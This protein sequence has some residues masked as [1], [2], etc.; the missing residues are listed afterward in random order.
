MAFV[1]LDSGTKPLQHSF[2]MRP[3]HM[4]SL[5]D[6][7]AGVNGRAEPEDPSFECNDVIRPRRGGRTRPQR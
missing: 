5:E 6:V 3:R 4:F 2:L 1:G 7:T